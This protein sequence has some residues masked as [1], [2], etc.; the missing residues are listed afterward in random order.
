MSGKLSVYSIYERAI[1][2]HVGHHCGSYG[3]CFNLLKMAHNKLSPSEKEKLFCELKKKW[4]L[5]EEQALML[6][7]QLSKFNFP[8]PKVP[9]KLLVPIKVYF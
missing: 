2:F 1:K 8:E 3:F 4:N 5:S 7:E 9:K 6:L